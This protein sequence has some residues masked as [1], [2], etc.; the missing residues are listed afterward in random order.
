MELLA[1]EALSKYTD[2][3]DIGVDV[4]KPE[5]LRMLISDMIGNCFME[6][7]GDGSRDDEAPARKNSREKSPPDDTLIPWVATSAKCFDQDFCSGC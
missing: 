1:H 7:P 3:I 5:T 6:L 2:G 4:Q